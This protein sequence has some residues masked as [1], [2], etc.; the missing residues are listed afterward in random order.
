M[1]ALEEI[2]TTL[3]KK[4][5]ENSLRS[6]DFTGWDAYE[7]IEELL[8]QYRNEAYEVGY[9]L[10]FTDGYSEAQSL[11]EEHDYERVS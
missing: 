5:K 8:E 3:L 9:S 6:I 11:Y 4:N 7:A 10:G 1:V 2:R